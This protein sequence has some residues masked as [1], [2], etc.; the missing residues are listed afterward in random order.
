[1]QK[2]EGTKGTQKSWLWPCL[3]P[4]YNQTHGLYILCYLENTGFDKIYTD[5]AHSSHLQYY[6]GVYA[7]KCMYN[8]ICF[9]HSSLEIADGWH[10][11]DKAVI[12][13]A[14]SPVSYSY[15]R[16]HP[17]PHLVS[18][19]AATLPTPLIPCGAYHSEFKHFFWF[20]ICMQMYVNWVPKARIFCL[21]MLEVMP[22]I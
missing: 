11:S 20:E 1:M 22:T 5:D 13:L 10:L 2:L 19:S 9:G 7:T 15:N 21:K 17:I 6:I 12:M 14:N 16:R 4:S 8:N 3:T 18:I